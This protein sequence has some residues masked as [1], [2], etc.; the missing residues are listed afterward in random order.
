MKTITLPLH[1][2]VYDH[3]DSLLG[4]GA[5]I[6]WSDIEAEIEIPRLDKDGRKSNTW[7]YKFEMPFR[8][9]MV[10][11]GWF[12]TEKGCSEEGFRI[13]NQEEVADAVRKGEIRKAKD[14]MRKAIGMSQVS[15]EDMKDEDK[16]KLDFEERRTAMIG[17]TT[18]HLLRKRTLPPPAT[19]E[20]I[21]K[22][23]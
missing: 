23:L 22:L 18:A 17:E 11:Q 21:R 19:M 2:H 5:Y 10:S 7:L 3:I 20:S 15:R 16:V 6:P 9:Y 12:I 8:E 14:T 1:Q 13:L 4:Y